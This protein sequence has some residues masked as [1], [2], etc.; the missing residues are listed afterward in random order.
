MH[1]DTYTF[2]RAR[3]YALRFIEP[4]ATRVPS[5][6]LG[7]NYAVQAIVS[8]AVVPPEWCRQN[9][10]ESSGWHVQVSATL[11]GQLPVTHAW[12]SPSV[13]YVCNLRSTS[14]RASR[15]GSPG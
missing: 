5:A 3:M 4:L 8:L 7:A 11:A 13:Q 14:Y 15:H 2:F 1:I 10:Q 9:A 12:P 6:N